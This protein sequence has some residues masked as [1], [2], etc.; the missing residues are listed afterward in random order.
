M[1]SHLLGAIY[2]EILWQINEFGLPYIACMYANEFV[3]RNDAEQSS[4]IWVHEIILR[5]CTYVR[6]CIAMYH[7]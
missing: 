3:Y 4:Y 1:N 5:T 6:E 7:M 2:G